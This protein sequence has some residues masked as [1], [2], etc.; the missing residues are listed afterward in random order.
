MRDYKVIGL[1]MNLCLI[2]SL[3]LLHLSCG[4]PRVAGD[5]SF[6][7]HCFCCDSWVNGLCVGVPVYF[8]SWACADGQGEAV[9]ACGTGCDDDAPYGFTCALLGADF[10]KEDSCEKHSPPRKMAS[11]SPLATAA[12]VDSIHSNVYVY[13]PSDGSEGDTTATGEIYFE[14][15]DCSGGSCDFEITWLH[16]NLIDV[17]FSGHSAEG[18]EM[19]NNGI[20]SGTKREDDSFWIDPWT[21]NVNGFGTLDGDYNSGETEAATP[22]I[23]DLSFEE[24]WIIFYGTFYSEDGEIVISV[25]L[26][27]DFVNYPPN[28]ITGPDLEVDCEETVQVHLD[29]KASYD[30]D[31]NDTITS[32]TWF[33][34]TSQNEQEV[35]ARSAEAEVILPTGNQKLVLNVGD[36]RGAFGTDEMFVHVVDLTEPELEIVR[37]EPDCLWPPNHKMVR[38]EL[39]KEI[40][41][42]ANDNCSDVVEVRISGVTSSEPEEGIGDG[43]TPIDFKYG[44]SA[45]C[46]RSERAG[47]NEGRVYSIT[48][49]AE[50]GYGN[51]SQSEIQV[52]VGHDERPRRRCAPLPEEDFIEDGDPR[53]EF[54]E[55]VKKAEKEGEGCAVTGVNPS[56][57]EIILIFFVIALGLAR[58]KKNPEN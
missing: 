1:G 25:D 26:V 17:E 41:V 50:D 4:T 52:R 15:G 21:A 53:C 57:P 33:L 36:D 48:V 19:I 24:G 20:F 14:G 3:G 42:N 54:T 5:D 12:I 31:G 32:Y 55:N 30:I 7:C 45:V 39:G 8:D 43:M 37:V 49:E 38:L 9:Q 34:E 2:V 51:V 11:K 35:I 46:L 44:P 58:R 16:L 29:A 22:V 40:I 28:A 18:V 6:T 23:G 56:G 47:P 27:A 13:L 10:Y